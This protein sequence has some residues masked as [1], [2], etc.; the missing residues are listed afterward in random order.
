MDLPAR[1]PSST[2]ACWRCST[3]M[4]WAWWLPGTPGT[5]PSAG[6]AV[7]LFVVAALAVTGAVFLSG[8]PRLIRPVLIGFIVLCVA[9]WVLI[10]DL[11]FLGGLGTDPNSMIPFALLAVA[12]YLALSPE[13]APA[14][15]APA[16]RSRTGSRVATCRTSSGPCRP[17]SP[18]A[19]AGCP[20]RTRVPA[21]PAGPPCR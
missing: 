4:N 3:S 15:A 9:D 12:G 10:E 5:P 2:T 13:T 18:A 11:G 17:G 8:R 20:A 14:V 7:N 19:R 16:T 6:F 1:T 21:R